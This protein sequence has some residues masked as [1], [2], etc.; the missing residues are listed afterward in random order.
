MAPVSRRP[1]TRNHPSSTQEVDSNE[2]PPLRFGDDEDQQE[3]VLTQIDES[4]HEYSPQYDNPSTMLPGDAND[5]DIELEN[6]IQSQK[7]QETFELNVDDDDISSDEEEVSNDRNNF[8][9]TQ[10]TLEAASV[11]VGGFHSNNATTAEHSALEQEQQQTSS[12]NNNNES[13]LASSIAAQLRTHGLSNTGLD[14]EEVLFVDDCDEGK[15]KKA[16]DDSQLRYEKRF[17]DTIASYGGDILSPLATEMKVNPHDLSSSNKV[18]HALCSVCGGEKTADKHEIMNK[19]FVLC[20]MKWDCLSGPNK[21]KEMQ[22]TSF[23]K[24]MQ[25]LTY[26]F[27][28]KG[29]QC[30][31]DKDFNSTGKFHGVMKR[32][33]RE[34]RKKDPSFGTGSRKAR[35]EK[36]LV[37]KFI[38]AIRDRSIRPYEDPEHCLICV[39]FILGYYCGLRGSSEH[40][41]LDIEMIYLGEYTVEDGPELAGIKWGGVK[42]PFS[43]MNQLNMTNC[44]L[45]RDQDVL[46]TFAEQPDHDC[47]DP[48]AVF[49]HFIAH[50]HP[51]AKKFYGRLVK[52]GDKLEGDR[53]QKEFGRP[54]WYAESGHGRANWNLGPSKHRAL[55]K[56][57]ALL[58]GVPNWEACTGHALRALCVTHCIASNLTAVDVAAKVR[59][60]SVNS[61][62]EYATDCGQRKVNRVLAMADASTKKKAAE[63]KLAAEKASLPD[64]Y[65]VVE[66]QPLLPENRE[67]FLHASKKR[68]IELP[69]PQVED[70]E[71]V[72]HDVLDAE[73]EA[74]KKKNE[75]LRLKRENQRIQEELAVASCSPVARR[76]GR[77]SY[78]PSYRSPLEDR[79][80]H[81]R[82]DYRSRDRGYRHSYPPPSNSRSPPS[83]YYEERHFEGRRGYHDERDVD[84]DRYH[85]GYRRG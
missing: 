55:C 43:K 23:C 51:K 69:E 72:N 10:N 76:H 56:K 85:G 46:L 63:K 60:A 45:P 79:H 57:I 40:I 17:F 65:V 80:F 18:D 30:V 11:L 19:C 8:T 13:I 35:V 5:I 48:H 78:P 21:G 1:A 7:E 81:V 73:L 67:K 52:Q 58:A 39:I 59:H 31:F 75:I 3:P 61:Q 29:I 62:K 47:F 27:N 6:Y 2:Y 28:R 15:N 20:G 44:K 33:W 84:Y 83:R 14:A 77:S 24:M 37:R 38:Q 71:N 34:V 74:L 53:L 32:K 82:E 54:V 70:Q 25:C 42:V 68:R 36:T 4:L 12:S 22:P 64:N 41:D 66:T 49:C 50:C 26:L 9:Y 16:Y